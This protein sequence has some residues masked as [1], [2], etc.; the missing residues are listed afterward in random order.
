MSMIRAGRD[1]QRVDTGDPDECRYW[2]EQFGVQ[3]DQLR[4]AVHAVG[5]RADD[6][7]DYVERNF[8][9]PVRWHTAGRNGYPS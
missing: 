1:R 9:V 5:D 3:P 6:V 4:D 8:V 2:C 7:R